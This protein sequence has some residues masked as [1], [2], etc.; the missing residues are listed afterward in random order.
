MRAQPGRTPETVT[1]VF[2]PARFLRTQGSSAANPAMGQ[3]TRQPSALRFW[4]RGRSSIRFLPRLCAWAQ[5]ICRFRAKSEG[6]LR[7]G[8]LPL[9][10]KAI[11]GLRALVFNQ[12]KFLMRIVKKALVVVTVL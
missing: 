12:R 11:G 9:S 10:S 3:T 8:A 4:P 5:D 2:S 1:E 7:C 6:C